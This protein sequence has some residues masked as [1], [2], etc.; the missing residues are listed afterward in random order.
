LQSVDTKLRE[1]LDLKGDLPAAVASLQEKVDETTNKPHELEKT[2]R[3]TTIERD[4]TDVEMISC[5]ERIEKYKKQQLQ[6]KSNKQYDAL[7][8]EIEQTETLIAQAEKQMETFEGKIQTCQQDLE[9]SKTSLAEMSKE[10]E[11]K[12]N[13]L[14]EVNK[15]HEIEESKL[16]HQR[17]KLIS[18]IAKDDLKRYERIRNAKEGQAIVA[19]KRNACGGCFNRVPPQKLLEL[20]QN[21]KLFVCEH[22]G[23]ILVSDDVVTKSESII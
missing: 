23:R 19:I 18:R 16:L 6:V 20:R 2:I 4:T 11:E 9:T 15:E 13:E 10:L 12:Q 14:R 22:C 7:T 21:N 3:Q 1:I 17:E 5:T 8:K